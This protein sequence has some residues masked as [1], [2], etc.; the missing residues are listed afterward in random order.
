M[1]TLQIDYKWKLRNEVVAGERVLRAVM[2]WFRLVLTAGVLAIT[3]YL[4]D[5]RLLCFL[6]VF[7]AILAVLF[8]RTIASGMSACICLVLC[9]K[10]TLLS[11]NLLL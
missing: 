2:V 1:P 7:T 3:T 8:G 4:G 11:E 10:T 5:M 9:H 6:A